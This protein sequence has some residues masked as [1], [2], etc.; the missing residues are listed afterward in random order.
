MREYSAQDPYLILRRGKIEGGPIYSE[1]H[2]NH[3]VRVRGRSA[4][5]R[6]T[7][8]AVAL[9]KTGPCFLLSIVDV[10]N[11]GKRLKREKQK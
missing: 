9:Y 3:V 2:Q 11:R 4:D 10:K 1:E 7:R 6:D 5:G 8:I